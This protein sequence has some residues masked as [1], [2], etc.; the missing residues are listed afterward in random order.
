MKTIITLC[1]LCV[2]IKSVAQTPGTFDSSFGNNGKAILNNKD[3]EQP[4]TALLV[5]PDKRIILGGSTR[6]FALA[7]LLPDG[8]IDKSF[9]ENGYVQTN[10]IVGDKPNSVSKL[11]SFALT[12]G[13]KILAG[14]SITNR[15][16]AD[17]NVIVA[18]YLPNGILDSAFGY[19]GAAIFDAGS[20]DDDCISVLIQPDQKIVAVGS[21]NGKILL[22]RFLSN[23]RLDS[24]FGE[25]G[26]TIFT[27]GD[28][29]TNYIKTAAIQSTGKIV[30]VFYIFS[31]LHPY[32]YSLVCFRANGQLDSSFGK[33]GLVVDRVYNNA[34]LYPLSIL[35]QHDDK[36]I[37]GGYTQDNKGRR[38]PTL[39][40][41]LETGRQDLNFGDS[42]F[43]YNEA[44]KDKFFYALAEQNNYK[45]IAA[46]TQ[47]DKYGHEDILIARYLANGTIDS[48]FGING[49]TI[50]DFHNDRERITSLAIQNDTKIVAGV[51]YDFNTPAVFRYF[52]NEK[53]LV[54]N[55]RMITEKKNLIDIKIFP[56]PVINELHIHGLNMNEETVLTITDV[57]GSEKMKAVVNSTSFTWNTSQ[58]PTGMYTLNIISTS[59]AILKNFF[60]E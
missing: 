45:I 18:R 44:D 60:K 20:I 57:N 30:I 5:L 15:V 41:Y 19:K 52:G 4:A 28:Y 13:G 27:A 50:N 55:T 10:F 3:V 11:N 2:A 48:T 47:E 59:S 24:S 17:K 9:G 58:L 25:N 21:T 43:V 53:K 56:N 46:G 6:D 26:K 32:P 7:C 35:I 39:A 37:I 1:F 54:Q 16:R 40:R 51:G 36:I 42:G 8:D 22:V 14:G 49:F 29:Y 38:R 31:S 23:G 12:A 33:H 34:T